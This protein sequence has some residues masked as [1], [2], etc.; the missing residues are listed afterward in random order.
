MAPTDR[1]EDDNLVAR[2]AGLAV[3]DASSGEARQQ[4]SPRGKKGGRSQGA[5]QQEKAHAAG[6]QKMP[7]D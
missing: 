6:K 7:A 4:R 5:R 2:T 1:G 3:S